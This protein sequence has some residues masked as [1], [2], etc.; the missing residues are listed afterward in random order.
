[1]LTGA[2]SVAHSCNDTPSVAAERDRTVPSNLALLRALQGAKA[3]EE[4]QASR[5]NEGSRK[6]FLLPLQGCDVLSVQMALA[7]R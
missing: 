3:G 4:K 1:M 6:G 2:T 7:V 5:F